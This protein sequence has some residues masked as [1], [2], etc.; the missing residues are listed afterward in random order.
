MNLA[1]NLI[2]AKIE[3]SSSSQTLEFKHGK[4]R[5][6]HFMLLLDLASPPNPLS[7][8]G[9][10]T[11]PFLSVSIFFSLSQ[12]DALPI[13]AGEGGVWIRFYLQ[14]IKHGH[15]YLFLFHALEHLLTVPFILPFLTTF[16]S[17]LV[18][19]IALPLPSLFQLSLRPFLYFTLLES[20][21]PTTLPGS[22][23]PPPPPAPAPLCKS[24]SSA[25]KLTNLN[26]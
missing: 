7:A 4:L 5:R 10:A 20:F 1:A 16:P 15:L 17:F 2:S 13:L 25:D 9:V 14:Q 3:F 26:R 22:I 21:D 6:P 23:P 11:L 24:C 12:V 8:N 19:S 18:F